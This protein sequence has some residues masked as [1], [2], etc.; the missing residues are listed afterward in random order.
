MAHEAQDVGLIPE[1][2]ERILHRLAIQ[3]QGIVVGAP[4][5]I[6]RIERS[7]QGAG[8]D[9]HP[10]IANDEFAGHKITSILPP[11]AKALACLG[12]PRAWAHCAIPW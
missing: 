7:I 11:A 12:R 6:P 3:S 5:P 1:L 9:A 8:L 4:G 2:T 10:A